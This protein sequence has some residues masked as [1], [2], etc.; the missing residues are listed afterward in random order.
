[1]QEA[2]KKSPVPMKATGQQPWRTMWGLRG[3]DLCSWG[4]QSPARGRVS[5]A[6]A[7]KLEQKERESF[8]WWWL[9]ERVVLHLL[10]C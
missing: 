6:G 9:R 5:A 4:P 7:E 8:W 3:Q 10:G 1:M 2:W